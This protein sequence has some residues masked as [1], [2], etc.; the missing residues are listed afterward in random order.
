MRECLM[1]GTLL[2][3]GSLG[4]SNKLQVDDQPDANP[5]GEQDSGSASDVGLDTSST[6]P[7]VLAPPGAPRPTLP[8]A[9]DS[10][11]DCPENT[12]QGDCEIESL[13]CAYRGESNGDAHYQACGC[14]AASSTQLWWACYDTWSTA[15]PDPCPAAMP[16]PTD[17][18][19]GARGVECHY[20]PREVCT[21][22]READDP[23][24]ECAPLQD[25]TSMVPSP[26]DL[27]P[28]SPVSDL[29]ESE[30]ETWCRW[31]VDIHNGGEG[32]PEPP[33]GEIDADGY[34]GG[35]SC[36]VGWE[37]YNLGFLP[38]IP[39]NYCV[40]NLALSTCG[41]PLSE[42]TDCVKTIRDIFPS[43]TGCARYLEAPGCDGT[44]VLSNGA[45]PNAGSA[46]L[47]D[48][49]CAVRVQ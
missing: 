19:M 37:F 3:A 41:R 47:D 48:I 16:A 1:F 26:T 25:Y 43:P 49:S 39:T 10:P 38:R 33:A 34:A 12:P 11:A 9:S 6:G 40:Q 42:L 18:C 14:F 36:T 5:L 27:D 21:C 32:F 7:R 44:I 20:L 4:C 29:T 22:S 31:K 15:A 13:L 28:T 8:V 45:D 23:L 2:V 46:G 30:R 24:W 35:G 17:S